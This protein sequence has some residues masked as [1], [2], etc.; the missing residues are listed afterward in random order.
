MR[1]KR[2]LWLAV[3]LL[4]SLSPLAAEAAPAQ[5]PR[6]VAAA[7]GP[8]EHARQLQAA[9]KG[10]ESSDPQTIQNALLSLQELKGRA[11]ADG[12]IA[13]LK[14]GLPPQLTE[15]A[16]SALS[17]LEQPIAVPVLAELTLHRRWQ[18]RERAIAALALLR[19]RSS[20]SV[21]LYALDDPSPEVRSAAARA[22]GQ[23]GDPRAHK[24]LTA[25]QARGVEGALEG[26]AHLATNQQVDAILGHARRDLRAAE[27]ALWVLVSRPTLPPVTKLKVIAFVK[28]HESQQEAAQLL[29]LWQNKVKESGDL[30]LLSALATT[31]NPVSQG[32]IAQKPVSPAQSSQQPSSAQTKLAEGPVQTGKAGEP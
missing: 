32:A 30:R 14:A 12:I 27:P 1:V 8:E 25:A 21:L 26:L 6:V 22:L 17:G 20:V 19:V 3:S 4:G 24:A 23:V 28:G 18:I 15:L 11:A 9:L 13:R 2:S 29:T 10:L 7:P 5:S 16:I 31:P